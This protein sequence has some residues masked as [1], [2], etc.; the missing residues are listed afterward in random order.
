MAYYIKVN[1]K[2]AE[3]LNLQNERYKTRDGNYL[4]WQGDM[5]AFGPL[6]E[7]SE[8][9]AKIGGHIIT[10][11][12]ARMEQKGEIVHELPIATDPR[13]VVKANV[14]PTNTEE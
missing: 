11:Q 7:L 5:A 9:A 8:S 4:L 13:F 12:E 3:F 1:P 2:V 14:E 6:W 10:A